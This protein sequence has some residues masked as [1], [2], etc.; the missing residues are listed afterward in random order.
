MKYTLVDDHG[1]PFGFYDS[2]EAADHDFDLL[3]R[4]DDMGIIITVQQVDSDTIRKAGLRLLTRI[5]ET[6]PGGYR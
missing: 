4:P 3:G 2:Q 6:F 5:S 1:T